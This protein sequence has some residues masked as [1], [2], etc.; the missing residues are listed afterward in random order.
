MKQRSLNVKIRE[1]I[2][3]DL[4]RVYHMGEEL[5]TSDKFPNLYRVWD[6]YAVTHMFEFEPELCLVATYRKKIIGFTLGY[7]IEKP[8]TAWSY[9]HLMWLGVDPVYQKMD[10][11]RRLLEQFTDIMKE[12]GVRILLIDTQADNKA[13]LKFF[14]KNGFR[15]PTK[16]LYMMKNLG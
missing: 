3:D 1:M 10:I 2:I 6:E 15:K 14:R 12:K 9:G 11:G 4:A 8:R 5:F 13:A 7:V 16:H